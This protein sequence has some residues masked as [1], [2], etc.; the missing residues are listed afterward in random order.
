[1]YRLSCW[2]EVSKEKIYFTPQN[3]SRRS[4][5]SP[6]MAHI[7]T[8]KSI[9]FACTYAL[10]HKGRRLFYQHTRVQ[11][12]ISHQPKNFH[13]AENK[14]PFVKWYYKVDTSQNG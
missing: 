5:F 6:Y 13:P 3:R 4:C 8:R 1:M 2:G 12:T 7:L 10:D 9:R 14:I 11:A